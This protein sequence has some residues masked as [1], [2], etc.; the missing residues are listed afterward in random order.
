MSEKDLLLNI[1]KPP[2]MIVLVGESKRGKSHL[3]KH[4]LTM[5]G[6]LKKYKFG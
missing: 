3:I 6:L 2:Q 1:I 5:Y 4:L